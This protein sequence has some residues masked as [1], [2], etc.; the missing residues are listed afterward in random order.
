MAV[1]RFTIGQV[2]RFAKIALSVS[3]LIGLLLPVSAFPANLADLRFSLVDGDVQIYTGDTRQW[4]PTS[5]N[6]P[7]ASEDRVW[8]PD[9][10]R[11]ELQLAD[12][13]ILRLDQD[14]SLD[15]LSL[16][17][18]TAQ[19]YMDQGG[20]YV[21]F[22][23]Y[24]DS[25]VQ[26]DTPLTSILCY[27]PSRFSID[28]S[29]DGTVTVSVFR[30]I[31]YYTTDTGQEAIPARQ[32]LVMSS[33]YAELD[34]IGPGTRWDQ[35]NFERDR[36]LYGS[37]Y[38]TQYLPDALDAYS[39]DFDNY[40]NWVYVPEYG[41]CWV[42]NGVP[43]GWAPYREGR[44]TWIAGDYVWV[45]YEPWGWAPYHYGR[46][47]FVAS[48]GWC[49]VPPPPEAVYWSP[50]Y[51]GWVNT[52]SYVAWVPLAPGDTYYGYGY[53][54]PNSVNITNIN[55]TNVRVTNVYR[56]VH[57]N[58]AVTVVN[59][60]SF[61]A[62]KIKPVH[63]PQ[64]RNPFLAGRI[65][66]GR[67]QIRPTGAVT[68]PVTKHIPVAK[69][70]PA[71]ITNRPVSRIRQSHPPLRGVIS[72]SFRPPVRQGTA[73]TGGRTVMPAPSTKPRLAPGAAPEFR[74]PAYTAPRQASPQRPAFNRQAPAIGRGA[75]EGRQA[76]QPPKPAYRRPVAPP[77]QRFAPMPR[78]V[79]PSV[80]RGIERFQPAQR[81]AASRPQ[82]SRPPQGKGKSAPK[83]AAPKKAPAKR[84]VRR[85][86]PGQQQ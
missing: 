38:S 9:A 15:V 74:R 73:P 85:Q 2:T 8:V 6:M 63:L 40:G 66:V 22:Q 39:A 68:M 67:P 64:R 28:I 70:P 12:G 61:V 46:W 32:K 37:D 50:G 72:P 13:S 48:V 1:E 36:R 34:P 75:P 49:W 5:V 30:G 52:G 55:I 57:V 76:V 65:N 21:N 84:E 80:Q 59:L 47:A 31:V 62:G 43:A 11:T 78:E 16:Q 69:R 24:K 45:S 3:F 53:F 58:N 83:K 18:D 79:R 60:R 71:V 42:P 44:W 7:L 86:G 14:S 23:G 19:F 20:A 82:V 33:D 4:V 10:G 81:P 51:V 54:G 27:D 35:W 25:M 56:N 41:N 26:V 77:Q 17:P 29:G